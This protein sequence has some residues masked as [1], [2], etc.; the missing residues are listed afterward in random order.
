MKRPKSRVNGA[1]L[2]RLRE[3]MGLTIEQLAHETVKRAILENKRGISARTIQRMEHNGHAYP[4]TLDRVADALG[5][6]GK[7][8]LLAGKSAERSLSKHLSDFGEFIEDRTRDFIGRRFVFDA[9]DDFVQNNKSGYFFVRGDPGI[10]KSSIVAQLVKERDYIHHFNIRAQ[11]INRADTFLKNV[12]AQLI[13]QY[14]LPYQSLPPEVGLDGKFLSKLLAEVGGKLAKK[15]KVVILVDALDEADES[16]VRPGANILY[17]PWRLPIGIFFVVTTR[18]QSCQLRLECCQGEFDL[19]TGG[20]ENLA[21]VEKY[22]ESKTKLPGIRAYAKKHKLSKRD[23]VSIM[24]DRSEGNF[25]YLRHVLPEIEKGAYKELKLGQI[26]VGLQNYYEDHWRRMGMMAKRRPSSKIRT[27]YVLTELPRP[28]SR[29]LL[30]ECC[31]LDEVK[32]QEILDEWDQFLH[33][34]VIDNTVCYSLYHTSF[35]DFLHRKEIIQAAGVS[36]KKINR[37]IVEWLYGKSKDE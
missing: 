34:S 8:L 31:K 18:R 16:S 23:F 9:V 22:L 4:Y 27:I 2:R 35:T 20:D 24:V 36:A 11:G 30:A 12:C 32:V 5:V 10:G 17:L 6:N 26:P 3:G 33:T 7:D 1:K 28:I 21:D 19:D 29:K 14:D 15:D 13:V 37:I 25:M